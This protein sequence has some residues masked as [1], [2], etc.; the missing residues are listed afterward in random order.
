LDK[1]EYPFKI[2]QAQK[3]Y[4]RFW[5]KVER[6]GEHGC[7][8]WQGTKTNGYGV[9]YAE[10]RGF[11]AHRISYILSKGSIGRGMQIDH[12]CRQRS[13]VKP[14]HLEAVTPQENIRRRDVAREAVKNYNEES[15]T[16]G[17]RLDAYEGQV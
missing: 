12:L 14:D 4:E 11:M 5:R 17:Y 1:W 10:G 15:P 6:N 9:T 8:L 16:Q 2:T 3:L 7:W 13:C